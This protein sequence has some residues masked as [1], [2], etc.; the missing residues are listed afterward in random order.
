MLKEFSYGAVVY[1]TNKETKFQAKLEAQLQGEPL[2]V[3]VRSKRSGNWGFPKG[4]EEKTESPLET[5]RREIYE[6]TGI[7]EIKF[8]KYFQRKDIYLIDGFLPGAKGKT[9]EKHS[10]YFLALA[11]NEPEKKY[12]EE[13][14]DLQWFDF[15][16]AL[17]KLSFKSQKEILKDAY[18]VIKSLVTKKLI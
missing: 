7:R 15:N 18:E 14:E 5:A 6:E 16:S 1:K 4:H 17:G 13:I 10:I 3:L 9:V 12:D 2:F 8:I 11:L